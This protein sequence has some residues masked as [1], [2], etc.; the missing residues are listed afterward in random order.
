MINERYEPYRLFYTTLIEN[1]SITEK[2]L[3]DVAK[4][5]VGRKKCVRQCQ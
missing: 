4:E 2:P 1:P 5:L 3:T